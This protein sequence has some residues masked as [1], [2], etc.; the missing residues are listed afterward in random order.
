MPV[1]PEQ[2]GGL[3]TPRSE[4]EIQ[5]GDGFNVF[6]GR[7]RVVN[8][9]GQN[10]TEQLIRGARQIVYNA[11]ITHASMMITKKKSP[12]C[13]CSRIYD[14]TFN[15]KLVDG[16]GVTAALLRLETNTTLKDLDM[17]GVTAARTAATAGSPGSSPDNR[18][19][20]ILREIL[21]DMLSIYQTQSGWNERQRSSVEIITRALLM[22]SS[23][24]SDWEAVVQSEFRRLLPKICTSVSD[25]DTV[26][27]FREVFRQALDIEVLEPDRHCRICTYPE[28]FLDT[29][30]DE[31]GICSACRVYQKNKTLIEDKENLREILRQKFNET[32]K[33]YSYDAAL[34][35]S[36]GKDS[37]YALTR[38]V[39]HYNARV[40]CVMDDLNQ[41][42]E[43]AMRNAK[44]AVRA[45]GAD[46]RLLRPP[47]CEKD[48]RRNFLRAGESFCRLCFRSHLIRVYQVALEER[49]PLVFLGSSPYQCL[50]CLDSIEWSLNAIREVSTPSDQIDYKTVI[51]TN[52]HRAFQGGFDRGFVMPMEKRLLRSWMNVYDEMLLDC[53][54]LIVPFFLFD[55]YPNEA[56]IMDTISQEA[57][58]E[59]PE[60]ALLR[61]TN[62]K[63]LRPAGI[64]HRV[65]G[66][67]HLNYKER[68]TELRF[69]GNMVS[70]DE[71]RN[72]FHKLNGVTSEEVMSRGELEEF[73]RNEFGLRIVDLPYHVQT[74]LKTELWNPVSF[75]S[76]YS[77]RRGEIGDASE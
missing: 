77:Y 61:R 74:R 37:V 16:M 42:T 71:A 70:E 3:P 29:Y 6:N 67:Y 45:T 32:R 41:Q 50:D 2:L 35:F 18:K 69:Q 23:M 38:L 26:R 11:Q 14:G 19:Q 54:P 63:W 33:G 49:I 76:P 15:R 75:N 24:K 36:G 53:T 13:S 51:E 28:G 30:L 27:F 43:Q 55:G 68:A 48:I 22:N 4:A 17:L 8:C 62:C 5:A 39:G 72:L 9:D 64:L 40:L 10:V 73:L 59:L 12:S 56:A 7:A 20:I 66:R 21:D 47:S 25:S 60:T 58:W 34:A 65:V 57:G 1:C 52:R 44:R 46:F 31:D